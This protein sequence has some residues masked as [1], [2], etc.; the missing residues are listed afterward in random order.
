MQK[1]DHLEGVHPRD[2]VDSEDLQEALKVLAYWL[3]DYLKDKTQG[4]A[5]STAALGEPAVMY[6]SKRAYVTY[7]SGTWSRKE[8]QKTSSLLINI[9]RSDMGHHVRKWLKQGEPVVTPMSAMSEKQRAV[10]EQVNQELE[11]DLQ[12]REK[13]RDAAYQIAEKAAQNDPELL[14]YLKAMRELN[15]YRSIS[16]RL[17]KTIPEVKA[18]EKRLLDLLR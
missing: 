17:K 15:D 3:T 10:M 7:M 11:E 12:L 8:G 5:F 1:F 13:T 14:K 16:K 2:E 18:L 6:F 9:A 4:G